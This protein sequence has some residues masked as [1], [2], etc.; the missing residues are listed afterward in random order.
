MIVYL[1]TNIINGKQ[2]VGKTVRSLNI[3]WREHVKAARENEPL[4]MLIVRAIKKYGKESFKHKI[5]E[6]CSNED[7]LNEREIF[8]IKEL[9]T[10]GGGYN[11]TKGGDGMSGYKHSDETRQ[12]MSKTRKGRK[13]SPEHVRAV[14]EGQ[15]GQKRPG[16]S[17]KRK[18]ELNPM[19]GKGHSDEARKKISRSQYKSV[20]Q[21][22]MDFN[23]L[24]IYPSMLMAKK[25]SGVGRQGVSACCRKVRNHAGGFRWKYASNDL[26]SECPKSS[27]HA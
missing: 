6:E 25:M 16:M 23:E 17:K 8:W 9:G 3:R 2:Y 1:I 7:E 11:L 22:D 26:K 21:M 12:K 19:Y 10:F 15:K 5:L 24:A 4:S 13:L 27:G 20:I 14:S 18:G